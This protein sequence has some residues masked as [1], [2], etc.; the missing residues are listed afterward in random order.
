MII[1]D[2]KTVTDTS[3]GHFNRFMSHTDFS[4]CIRACVCVSCAKRL[5]FLRGT[6]T[7]LAFHF[8]FSRYF[9]GEASIVLYA[10]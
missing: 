4:V 10:V 6:F 9:G 1:V 8:L 3:N 7:K 5:Y 2:T